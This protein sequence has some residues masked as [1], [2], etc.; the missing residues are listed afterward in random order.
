MGFVGLIG[1][2]GVYMLFLGVCRGF[3]AVVGVAGL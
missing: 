2:V 3:V 1:L